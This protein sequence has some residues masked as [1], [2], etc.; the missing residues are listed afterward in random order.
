MFDTGRK[1]LHYKGNGEELFGQGFC[2]DG[3]GALYDDD[4]L[5][6]PFLVHYLLSEDN[7]A[8][9]GLFTLRHPSL[10]CIS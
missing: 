9:H 3:M 1:C 2:E 4:R 10:S 7:R 6:I 8:L 5:E